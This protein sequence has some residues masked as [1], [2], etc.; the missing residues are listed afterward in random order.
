[1]RARN[2]LRSLI[3]QAID[4]DTDATFTVNG[5]VFTIPREAL[6]WDHI[7]FKCKIEPNRRSPRQVKEMTLMFRLEETPLPDYF[8]N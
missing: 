5:Q 1:M 7:H 8:S 4:N 2:V 3:I 6:Q